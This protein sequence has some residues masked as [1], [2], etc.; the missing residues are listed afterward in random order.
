LAL[1]VAVGIY[2]ALEPNAFDSE[3]NAEGGSGVLF[4]VA[5]SGAFVGALLGS[6]RPRTPDSSSRCARIQGGNAD[7][8]TPR[9]LYRQARRERPPST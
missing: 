4:I 8:R 2:R 3:Y 7:Y 6:R 9:P 5:V 1:V